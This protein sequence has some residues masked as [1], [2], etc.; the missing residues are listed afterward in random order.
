V[1]FFILILLRCKV[2]KKTS[3][4]QEIPRKN[5]KAGRITSSYSN[6]GP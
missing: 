3:V 5:K 1:L 4:I 2:K 6:N